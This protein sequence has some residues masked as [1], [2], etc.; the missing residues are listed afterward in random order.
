MGRGD[1][2]WIA[3]FEAYVFIDAPKRRASAIA[4][5]RAHY[6][7]QEDMSGWP[8][9][10]TCCPWCGGDLDMPDNGEGEE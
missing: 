6:G 8:Y 7:K 9:T 5:L 1:F 10:W 3:A 4:K 2:L